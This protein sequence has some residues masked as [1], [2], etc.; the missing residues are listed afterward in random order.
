MKPEQLKQIEEPY[1]TG[2]RVGDAGHTIFGPKTE[3]G[4]LPERIA[5]V[6]KASHARFI[7]QTCNNHERLLRERERLLDALKRVLDTPEP[8]T[9]REHFDYSANAERLARAAIA[10][11]EE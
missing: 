11:A 5:D 7:V 10:F 9:C 1:P 2:W 6:R 4:S 3:D 8:M